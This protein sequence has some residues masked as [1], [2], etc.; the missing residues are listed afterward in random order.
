MSTTRQVRD[1]FTKVFITIAVTAVALQVLFLILLVV[2][3]L[4]LWAD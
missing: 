2:G 3:L 1:F 4:Q